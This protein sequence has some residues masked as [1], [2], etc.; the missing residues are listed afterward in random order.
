MSSM[1][2]PAGKREGAEGGRNQGGMSQKLLLAKKKIDAAP[3]KAQ[4]LHQRLE[5]PIARW[6]K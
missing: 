5:W 3:S 4:K 1:G 6:F 2:T